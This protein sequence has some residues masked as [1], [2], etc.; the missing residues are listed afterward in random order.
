MPQNR[1]HLSCL[2]ARYSANKEESGRRCQ[3]QDFQIR[4]Q[5]FLEP[6]AGALS[7]P[8]TGASCLMK[9]CGNP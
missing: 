2:I 9:Y 1:R 8:A 4:R 6:A 7:E 5:D 3:R